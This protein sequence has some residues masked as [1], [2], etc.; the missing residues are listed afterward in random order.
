VQ[1]VGIAADP[2]T[3]FR[4]GSGCAET[5]TITATVKGATSVSL[6]WQATANG[7]VIQ[8]GG[9]DMVPA[10]ADTYQLVIGGFNFDFQQASIDVTVSAV[11]AQGSDQRIATSLVTWFSSCNTVG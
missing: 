5:S 11:G 7:G 4:T 10:G 1:I 2:T 9:G 3:I 8:T 6:K